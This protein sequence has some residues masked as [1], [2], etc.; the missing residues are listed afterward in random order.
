M[1]AAWP[2][3][4]LAA[5]GSWTVGAGSVDVGGRG[6]S[7]ASAEL[8]PRLAGSGTAI[9]RVRWR[10]RLPP[11][12]SVAATLCA[13]A[14]CIDLEGQRGESTALAGVSARTPLQFRFRLRAGD[15]PPV[16]VSHIELVVDH[17]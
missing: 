3:L 4:A 6:Q 8:A 7:Y 11:G 10:Y 14:R 12:R 2:A 1:L 15:A 9:R 5:Q 16:R 17:D 13:G